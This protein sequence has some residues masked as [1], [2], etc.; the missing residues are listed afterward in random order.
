LTVTVVDLAKLLKIRKGSAAPH[1]NGIEQHDKAPPAL[2]GLRIN[3]A[4]GISSRDRTPSPNTGF[5]QR[6]GFGAS[7]GPSSFN[8]TPASQ[9]TPSPQVGRGNPATQP[10]RM[11]STANGHRRDASYGSQ[12]PPVSA[13]DRNPQEPTSRNG[14]HSNSSSVDRA[15]DYDQADGLQREFEG[16]QPQQDAELTEEDWYKFKV[17]LLIPPCACLSRKQDFLSI[18]TT[19]IVRDIQKLLASLRSRDEHSFDDLSKII[20]TVTEMLHAAR[21]HLPYIDSSL[22][23]LQCL[24]TLQLETEKLQDLQQR[25]GQGKSLVHDKAANSQVTQATYAIVKA[26]KAL[27]VMYDD[28]DEDELT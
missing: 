25:A 16:D 21:E 28:K 19:D 20:A 6:T 13:Y 18:A 1:T 5:G 26:T 9:Y 7:N 8:S 24:E 11:G 10:L 14:F 23:D 22:W 17:R 3:G 12:E 27:N 2:E 4:N 15:S